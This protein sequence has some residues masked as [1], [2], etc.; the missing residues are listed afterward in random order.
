MQ[1]IIKEIGLTQGHPC[2]IAACCFPRTLQSSVGSALS[3]AAGSAPHQLP[4]LGRNHAWLGSGCLSLGS[5]PRTSERNSLQVHNKP[6]RTTWIS[7]TLVRR[8]VCYVQIARWKRDES[9]S[10][11]KNKTSSA[12]A[13][14]LCHSSK[15]RNRKKKKEREAEYEQKAPAR[16]STRLP[17]LSVYHILFYFLMHFAALASH[18][19]SVWV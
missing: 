11:R 14:H 8:K 16:H 1:I 4:C 17:P 7:E 9:T 13:V 6:H 12:R 19:P 3:S 18:K 2:W 5:C 15:A 10:V